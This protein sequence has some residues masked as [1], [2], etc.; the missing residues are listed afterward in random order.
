MVDRQKVKWGIYPSEGFSLW[1]RILSSESGAFY[2]Q[3]FP[4]LVLYYHH[5]RGLTC[6]PAG[7]IVLEPHQP[8]NTIGPNLPSLSVSVEK[9]M[10]MCAE[11]FGL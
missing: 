6:N 2:D 5:F 10:S 1:T 8:P 3:A 11:I 9:H 7:T 4:T